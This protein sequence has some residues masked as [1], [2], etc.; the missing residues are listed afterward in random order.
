MRS[1]G[2][3]AILVVATVFLTS[4]IVVVV[5]NFNAWTDAL[6]IRFIA[7]GVTPRVPGV[8]GFREPRPPVVPVPIVPGVTG[9]REPAP[10][11]PN[12]PFPD[13]QP[14]GQA[15]D[16]HESPTGTAVP[17]PLEILAWL[18]VGIAVMGVMLGLNAA[19]LLR[20]QFAGAFALRLKE[21]SGNVLSRRGSGL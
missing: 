10:Q 14:P 3:V 16:P 12:Q 6:E 9:F 19:A 5:Y 18:I 15:P 20:G 21:R 8:T 13:E 2:Q 11:I 4:Y 7:S 1:N 17:D